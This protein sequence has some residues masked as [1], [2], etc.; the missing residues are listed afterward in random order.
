MTMDPVIGISTYQEHATWRGW[1]RHASLVP[2]DFLE[3]IRD[4]GG[5]QVLLP[6][7]QPTG[8][9]AKV[10]TTLDG[11]LL[12]GGA[13]IDPARY[14]ALPHPRTSGLQPDRDEWELAL[15]RAALDAD[16]P[17]LGVCRGMQLIN[18]IQGGTLRQHLPD[19]QGIYVHQPAASVFQVNRIT[20]DGGWE[21]GI[22]LGEQADV[23]CY[24]H[25]AVGQLGEGIRATAWSG[26][27]TIEAITMANRRFV[28]GVQWHVEA[29]EV[30]TLFKSF[31]RAAVERAESQ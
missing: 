10:A 31:V 2:M 22:T 5:A 6:P 25:Q 21:P 18:I 11:L 29:A 24:H 23:P 26:D 13:D 20:M 9:A 27:G 8:V 16:L 14:N 30:R 1:N 28:V 15:L 3:A 7:I 19:D 17:V 12:V 4:S